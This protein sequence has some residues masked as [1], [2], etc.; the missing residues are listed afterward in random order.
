MRVAVV[1]ATGRVGRHV[2]AVLEERGHDAV[3]ISRRLGVDVITGEGL[4]A[5]LADVE[6]II[7]VA[8]T[9]SPDRQ[10]AT[11]YFVTATGNL[12]EVGE[13]AGVGR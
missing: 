3:P 6:C 11:E 5:A 1:G 2:V 9:S 7:D 13:Q 4:A 10:E 8:T 12:H